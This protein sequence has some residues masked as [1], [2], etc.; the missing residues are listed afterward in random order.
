MGIGPNGNGLRERVSGLRLEDLT[1]DELVLAITKLQEERTIARALAQQKKRESMAPKPKRV[2]KIKVHKRH[3][4]HT[5][6]EKELCCKCE[7]FSCSKPKKTR[8]KKDV[9]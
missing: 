2:P 9:A 6:E 1:A 8:K 4:M 7:K 5:V 3:C